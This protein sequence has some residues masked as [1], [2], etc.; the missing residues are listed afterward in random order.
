[1]KRLAVVALALAACDDPDPQPPFACGDI[2]PQEANV[3]GSVTV[4]PCFEDPDGGTITLSA[5]SAHETTAVATANGANVIVRSVSPGK[6][7]VTVTAMDLDS[8]TADL[9]FRM[10]VPNRAPE[11]TAEIPDAAIM[12]GDSIAIDLFAHFSD[13]DNQIL[14]YAAA[15][16][17][18]DVVGVTVDDSH[19]TVRAKMTGRA[20]VTVDAT[21]PG[22]LSAEYTFLVTVTKRRGEGALLFDKFEN[23]IDGWRAVGTRTEIHHDDGQLRVNQAR[24]AWPNWAVRHLGDSVTPRVT[25]TAKANYETSSSVDFG[26]YVT[27]KPRWITFTV[28]DRIQRRDKE[29][30]YVDYTVHWWLGNRWFKHED[31]YGETD[32]VPGSGKDFEFSVTVDGTEIELQIDGKALLEFD[33]ADYSDEEI[34]EIYQIGIGLVPRFV[35]NLRVTRFDWVE[36]Q[37]LK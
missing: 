12:N 10:T 16:T 23:D 6:T 3:G 13:P 7:T 11:A 26:L 15:S 20:T 19:L 14:S 33:F 37:E 9:R 35:Y 17:L 22:G 5:K 30:T 25:L 31:L 28:G 34:G 29:N 18:P 24:S 2:D 1:M 36:L 32:L 8:L 27:G 4:S 21:D